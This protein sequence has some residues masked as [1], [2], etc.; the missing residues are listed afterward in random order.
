[1]KHLKK[2]STYSKMLETPVLDQW[3][4][5]VS[6]RPGRVITMT[7]PKRNCQLQRE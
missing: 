5:E 4:S 2:G 1:M 7:V 3:R 6:W